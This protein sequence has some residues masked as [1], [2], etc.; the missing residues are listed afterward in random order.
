MLYT[1]GL[2]VSATVTVEDQR[3]TEM[4]TLRN[5]SSI[6]DHSTNASYT[7]CVQ[8]VSSGCHWSSSSKRCDWT[9][10]P[11]PQSNI[12]DA[13]KHLLSQMDYKKPEILSLEPNKVS[14]HGKNNVSLKGRNLE[15]VTKIR[16]KGDLDCIP[17][18]SLVFDRFS[19]TLWFHIP[20]SGTKGTVKVCVVTPDDRCHGNSIITYGSQPSCTGIQPTVSWNSGGRKIH[21]QGSNLEF[22]E[23]VSVSNMK[24]KYNT[25]SGDMWFHSPQCYG[26][27]DC[28][29]FNLHVGDSSLNYEYLSYEPDPVFI[30]FTTFQVANDLQVKIKKRAD[31][32]HLSVNE[33]TVMG[34][35][36]DQQYQCV[37]EEIQSKAVICKIKGESG[38]VTA[39]DSLKIN[40]GYFSTS[41]RQERPEY[42]GFFSIVFSL[43]FVFFCLIFLILLSICRV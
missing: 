18:E 6:T 11:G 34:Q 43:V 22:V 20:P 15:S 23:S 28:R 4:L 10:G 7:Q 29:S 37:L 24:T 14:F 38:A 41:L 2:K 9:L 42:L 39:V 8:C 1:G 27:Y 35:Q 13:C 16:I 21:V 12:K 30:G 32:L 3:I 40:V 17:K 36:G 25:S 19:D 26:Y 31:M 5:C 33:V